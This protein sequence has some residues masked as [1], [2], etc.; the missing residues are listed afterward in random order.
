M[1]VYAINNGYD[2]CCYPRIMLPVYHNGFLADKQ[3]INGERESAKQ[4]QANLRDSDVVL[5]H[6]PESKESQVLFDL[7]KA[8][9]KKVVVDNDDTFKIEDN[10][11]L[12]TWRSDAMKVE[13]QSRDES[14]DRMAK[15]ADLLTTST[16]FLAKEYR[17]LNDNV[18]V[19]PNCI[20][21]M[22]WDEPLRGEG[23]VR[24]GVVGS[25]AYAYDYAHIKE[26]LQELSD[27]EDVQLVMFGF[28]D[29]KHR[30]NNPQ[31]TEH[32]KKEYDFW[33]SLDIEQVPWCKV[34][35]Y[36]SKLNEARLDIML[37]PRRENYFNKCKSNIKFLEAGMCEIPVIAQSFEDAPYEEIRKEAI[38]GKEIGVLVNEND[39]WMEEIDRLV[40]NKEL[41]R[42]IGKNAREYVL[43]NYNIEDHAHKWNDAY[44]KICEK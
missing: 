19:L 18:L 2:G 8:D 37:I 30:E 7:L 16:E 9:G 15:E 38:L 31:I 36:P 12:A 28:G 32:F 1:K 33:D 44:Q 3:T 25:T 21:P 10:H 20:D 27:R 14:F 42:E 13:L 26:V 41:R 39:K 4:A 23:K 40:E 11:P 24:I 34:S 22:D 43:K 6:R 5:M 35:D 29:T 17:E